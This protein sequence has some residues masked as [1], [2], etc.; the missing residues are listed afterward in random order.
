MSTYDRT[1]G[2]RARSPTRGLRSIP[3]TNRLP[4]VCGTSSPSPLFLCCFVPF[5]HCRNSPGRTYF[6]HDRDLLPGAPVCRDLGS[7]SCLESRKRGESPVPRGL[8][9][10]YTPVYLRVPLIPVVGTRYSVAKESRPVITIE[11]RL[12]VI[13]ES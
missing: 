11:P 3:G 9:V 8:E 7:V 4:V 10:V 6:S 13:V 5:N 1:R 2:H 12:T